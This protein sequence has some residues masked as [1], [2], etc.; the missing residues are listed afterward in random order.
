MQEL[1]KVQPVVIGG[2]EVNAVNARDLHARL[3][4]KTDF[5]DWIKGR[6]AKFDFL[7]GVDFIDPEKKGTLE[8]MT[9]GKERAKLSISSHWTWQK[10]CRWWKTTNKVKSLGSIS[11]QWRKHSRTKNLSFLNFR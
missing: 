11:S 3:E 1:V 5:S 7:Q 10:N 6:I 4:V 9:Y 8:S 2:E